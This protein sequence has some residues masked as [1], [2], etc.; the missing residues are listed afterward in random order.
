VTEAPANW[1]AKVHFVLTFV[2]AER[3]RGAEIVMV[4][5]NGYHSVAL[6]AEARVWT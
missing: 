6:G 1:N 4:A 5:A 2:A 3:F